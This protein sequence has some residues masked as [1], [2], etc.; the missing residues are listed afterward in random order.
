MCFYVCRQIANQV[1]P[2]QSRLAHVTERF[3]FLGRISC[4]DLAMAPCADLCGHVTAGFMSVA[5][6]C[7]HMEHVTDSSMWDTDARIATCKLH[8]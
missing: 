7:N 5:D 8:H 3:W 1:P 6:A 2:P 4:G